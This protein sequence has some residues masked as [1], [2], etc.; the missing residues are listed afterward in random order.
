MEDLDTILVSPEITIKEAMSH[1]DQNAKGIVVVVDDE[2][3]LLGTITD[4]D[5]RRS[6]LDGIDLDNKVQVLLNRKSKTPYPEPITAPMGTPPSEILDLMKKHV[7][8]QI[9]I[10][11]KKKRVIDIKFLSEMVSK[12]ELT[13]DAVV[14]AGGYG[15]RLRPLTEDVPKPMLQ[16][17][18][19]PLM[20]LI[21]DRLRESGIRQVNITTHYLADKIKEH[22]DDG[23]DF[24]VE[25]DYMEEDRPLGTAGALGLMDVS[26]QP[27]LVMNGDILTRVD[28]RSMLSFH[29]EHDADLTVGVRQY[30][31]EVPYGVVE[32]KGSQ[33]RRLREK[34][35]Y[36][37]LVNAGIYLL[38]PAVHSYIPNDQHFDMTD[39][40]EILLDNEKT[41]ISFPIV[42]YWL[43]IGEPLDYEKAQEDFESW[44]E[45][46]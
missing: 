40:I 13:L 16:V 1:I 37:F 35:R 11:D 4:G 17:G 46:D 8:Q 19:R 21:I 30:G 45:L 33:V 22:F 39:L 18:E 7:I 20:E 36:N 27:L 43:D 42:E 26:D 25:I 10:V 24:G 32:C 6:I 38:E 3:H 2:R 29:N 12:E 15:T 44:E 14:M 34:P 41:V 23:Q 9:P 28:F 31:L 5:I